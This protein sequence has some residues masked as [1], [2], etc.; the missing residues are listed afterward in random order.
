MAVFASIT[1]VIECNTN[2]TMRNTCAS[3][4][5]TATTPAL[6]IQ[7]SGSYTFTGVQLK[8]AG[9]QTV[10]AFSGNYLKSSSAITVEPFD[11]FTPDFIAIVFS[12]PPFTE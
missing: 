12:A 7:L 5:K 2:V 6:S 11:S 4:P 1:V 8:T 9:S 10:S 3:S